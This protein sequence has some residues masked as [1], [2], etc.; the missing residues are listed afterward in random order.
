[1]KGQPLLTLGRSSA[2]FTLKT[3]GSKPLLKRAN[4]SLRKNALALSLAH[5]KQRGPQCAAECFF[6]PT[7]Y[8]L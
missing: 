7:Q 1:M 2:T 6:R 3:P 8:K 5:K 4:D